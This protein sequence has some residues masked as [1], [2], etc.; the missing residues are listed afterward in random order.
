MNMG[1]LLTIM[2]R[3]YR[4]KKY[5]FPAP[6]I[7]LDNKS[8][9]DLKSG[10]VIIIKDTKYSVDCFIRLNSDWL[11]PEVTVNDLIIDTV[12]LDKSPVRRS[13]LQKF[14]KENP[15]YTYSRD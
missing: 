12:D 7:K 2:T 1:L 8:L 5:P 14:Y 6:E 10:L 9:E 13:E 15:R 4:D 3:G 11:G